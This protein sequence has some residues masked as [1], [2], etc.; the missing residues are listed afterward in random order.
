MPNR[1]VPSDQEQTRKKKAWGVKVPNPLS[2]KKSQK[3]KVGGDEQLRDNEE[4][5][6]AMSGKADG[7]LDVADTLNIIERLEYPQQSTEPKRKRKRKH[8]PNK[9]EELKS[10]IYEGDEGEDNS[11]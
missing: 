3:A 10:V 11:S 1:T 6:L 9:I 5:I 8:K 2:V 7:G 4:S